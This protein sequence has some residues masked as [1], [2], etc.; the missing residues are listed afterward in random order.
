M[1]QPIPS[2][3]IEYQRCIDRR[4]AMNA[5]FVAAL[6]DFLGDRSSVQG[7]ICR[8]CGRDY[9]GDFIAGD[10]DSDDCPSHKARILIAQN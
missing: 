5:Q 6:R 4:R 10:C 2:E 1:S 8:H 3:T 9:I 7:G